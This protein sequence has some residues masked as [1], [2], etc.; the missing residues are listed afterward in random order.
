MTCPVHQGQD[1]EAWN[2][3]QQDI[4]FLQLSAEAEHADNII[5]DF[6]VNQEDE[7]EIM[8]GYIKEKSRT[9]EDDLD[10]ERSVHLLQEFASQ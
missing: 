10:P 6:Q 4:S 8:G 1:D 5:G 3:L 7:I 2:K 9:V